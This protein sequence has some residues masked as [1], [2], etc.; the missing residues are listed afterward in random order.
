MSLEIS[1]RSTLKISSRYIA[2]KVYFFLHERGGGRGGGNSM[3][4]I[5]IVILEEHYLNNI[6]K[7]NGA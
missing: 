1:R 7:D 6:F 5:S 3:Q 4:R 2:L